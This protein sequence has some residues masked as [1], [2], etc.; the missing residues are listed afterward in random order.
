MTEW[1][2]AAFGLVCGQAPAHTW[3]P[4]GFLGV[5]VFFV[6]SGFLITG[7]LFD[8]KKSRRYFRDFY[9]RRSLRI[10]PLYFA[11]LALFFLVLPRLLPANAELQSAK[12]DAIWY[13]SYLTNER[14]AHSLRVLLAECH[15]L[16][17][18]KPAH[19]LEGEQSVAEMQRKLDM[20]EGFDVGHQ[21][22]KTQRRP[23][24]RNP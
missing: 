5:D 24:R 7:I 14:I 9:A 10:F 22:G 1:V 21:A 6:V 17:Y 12:H 15:Y 18:R 3:L 20:R 4:G 13:L 2:R 8:S 23:A 16:F 11:T 19:R